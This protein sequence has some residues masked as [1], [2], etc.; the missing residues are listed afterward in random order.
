MTQPIAIS[1][2]IG[3]LGSG[4]VL[5]TGLVASIRIRITLAGP[6]ILLASGATLANPTFELQ[7]ISFTVAAYDIQDSGLY[8]ESLKRR[9]EGGG[10][11]EIAYDNWSCFTAT[12]PSNQNSIRFCINT[13][14]LDTVIATFR[15]V[16]TTAENIPAN[17]TVVKVP[18]TFVRIGSNGSD[19]GVSWQYNVNGILF[20]NFRQ[21]SVNTFVSNL[22]AMGILEDSVAGIHPDCNSLTAFLKEF[23]FAMVSFTYADPDHPEK[24]VAGLNTLGAN[25]MASFDYSMPS[26]TE[27]W[28]KTDLSGGTSSSYEAVIFA[29]AKS[30]LQISG[31]RMIQCLS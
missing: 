27:T 2:F 10:V 23:W 18:G 11:L 29:K 5:D 1:N 22:E 20:N 8:Y 17:T 28:L 7:N 24:L 31:G 14:S 25:T 21:D 13:A 16:L 9:V 19:A 12:N 3:F 6:E 30:V 26:S 15:R 4:Q